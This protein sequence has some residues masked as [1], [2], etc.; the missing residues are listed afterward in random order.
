MEKINE[1]GAAPRSP[2]DSKTP[3]DIAREYL[4]HLSDG[5][6]DAIIWEQTG[7]PGFWN[8]PADGNTPEECFRSQ[9]QRY[10]DFGMACYRCGQ[11]GTGKHGKP[12]VRYRHGMPFCSPCVKA[13][14]ADFAAEAA[15]S[16]STPAQ[17]DTP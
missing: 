11:Y 4:P 6:L 2:T 17:K 15:R 14:D 3:L 16:A 1:A 7:F 12:Y 9:L 13:M 8:I 5:A 10:R